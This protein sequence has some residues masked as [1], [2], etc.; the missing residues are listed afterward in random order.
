M[1]DLPSMR[2]RAVVL[3]STDPQELASFYQRLLGW[4]REQDEPEWVRLSDPA[5]GPGL[6][7]QLEPDH[8][9]PTWPPLAGEQQMMMHL[10]VVVDDLTAAS[11]HAVGV[12]A[13]LAQ[14]QPEKGVLVHLDPAGHP[15]C[16]F[17]AGS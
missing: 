17:L 2:L 10:D 12:G 3:G 4:D 15:F 14:H 11:A 8:L 9:P 5:G 1:S 6:S 13:R 16:L 7:F